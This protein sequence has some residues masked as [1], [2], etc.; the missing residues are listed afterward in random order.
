MTPHAGRLTIEVVGQTGPGNAAA[1]SHTSSVSS[2]QSKQSSLPF[3]KV[4]TSQSGIVLSHLVETAVSPSASVQCRF[5]PRQNGQN[6]PAAS[7]SS[8]VHVAAAHEIVGKASGSPR[9]LIIK[10]AAPSH[11]H[12][13]STSY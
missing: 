9:P 10:A 1:S 12:V 13:P 11:S 3:T 6:N 4:V 7:H 5:A 2:P 8:S